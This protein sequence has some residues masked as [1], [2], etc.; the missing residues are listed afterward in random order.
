MKQNIA[1]CYV[2]LALMLA[3]PLGNAATIS[4]LPTTSTIAVGDVVRLDVVL[5]F[6]ADRT[7]GG[8][9]DFNWDPT[10][11]R[12]HGFTFDTSTIMDDPFF[13]R[14][15]YLQ[16][17]FLEAVGAGSFDGIDDGVLGTIS[18]EA[19]G[20]GD[21]MVSMY[22]SGDPGPSWISSDDFVT[23]LVP[24]FIDANITVDNVVVPLPAGVWLFLG[25]LG[26]LIRVRSSG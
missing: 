16:P 20:L 9:I 14:D 2:V 24:D 15:G 5:D 6:G 1:G 4:L 3:A 11:L 10:V 18:F 23:A 12:F 19:I 13:R 17:G 7:L 25:A 22:D 26:T 8:E 21:T